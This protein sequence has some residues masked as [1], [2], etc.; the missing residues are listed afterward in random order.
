[1]LQLR[2]E[3]ALLNST[4]PLAGESRSQ[5]RRGFASDGRT[6]CLD[7]RRANL[8]AVPHSS[9]GQINHIF[10]NG[11]LARSPPTVFFSPQNCHLSDKMCRRPPRG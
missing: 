4:L 3:S 10:L 9:Q 7:D 1:M 8:V 5:P 11:Q 6:F 2:V